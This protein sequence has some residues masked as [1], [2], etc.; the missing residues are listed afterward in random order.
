M[1]QPDGLPDAWPTASR[2]VYENPWMR[3]REDEFRRRD[4]STGV[5][6]VVDKQD[7]AIVVAEENGCFHLVEQFR[8][9]IARRSWEFPMGGWPPGKQGTMLELAQ[10][11]LAEETGL[12]AGQWRLL[13]GPRLAPGFA[14]QGFSIFH[15][16]DLAHGEHRREDSELDMVHRAVTEPELRAMILDGTIVDS[17]T[18]AAYGVLLLRRADMPA[19]AGRPSD[20][21][22]PPAP[23]R[24]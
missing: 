16:S 22:T 11:E 14:S 20:R 5:Y 21:P 1:T 12:T 8:Y 9:P 10:A 23:Y 2:T 19:P 17:S 6:G 18:I 7:F 3:V 24:R 13:A 4:G 15:A